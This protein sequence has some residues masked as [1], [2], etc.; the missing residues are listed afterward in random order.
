MK[1][2][3]PLTSETVTTVSPPGHR[4][5][6]LAE[7]PSVWFYIDDT[8]LAKLKAKLLKSDKAVFLI[9]CFSIESITH[10]IVKH[11]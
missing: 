6:G 7:S 3:E 9:W 10:K 4:S 8:F 1:G 5:N 11:L 2:Y